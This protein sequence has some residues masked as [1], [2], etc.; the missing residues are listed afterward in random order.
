MID[1]LSAPRTSFDGI[2]YSLTTIFIV[3]I[4]EDWNW[5]MY[6]YIRLLGKGYSLY[7]VSLMILGNTMLLSLFTAILLQNFEEKEEKDDEE[8]PEDIALSTIFT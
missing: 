7:F 1:E 6:D 8:D 3:I 4:G 5:V 2:F